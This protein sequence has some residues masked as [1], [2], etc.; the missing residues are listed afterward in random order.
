[1]YLLNPLMRL[2]MKTIKNWDEDVKDVVIVGVYAPWC[3][4]CR[5]YG[6]IFNAVAMEHPELVFMHLNSDKHEDLC[7]KLDIMG[8]PTTLL[9]ID[10]EVVRRRE[11]YMS[12]KELLTWLKL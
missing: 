1:M 3:G 12:K 10:G 8:L 6:P 2:T 9:T 4:V 5:S 11:G 7:N